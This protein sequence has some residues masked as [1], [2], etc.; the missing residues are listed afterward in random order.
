MSPVAHHYL[1]L[2]L[3]SFSHSLS[4][5]QAVPNACHLSQS[6]VAAIAILLRYRC[7]ARLEEAGAIVFDGAPL[8]SQEELFA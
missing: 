1:G 7:H 5:T 3:S 6:T 4:L 2:P 8:C